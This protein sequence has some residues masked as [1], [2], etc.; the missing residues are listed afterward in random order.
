MMSG[1]DSKPEEKRLP[2]QEVIKIVKHY[3]ALTGKDKESELQT[4]WLIPMSSL[5][6][7]A[8]VPIEEFIQFLTWAVEENTHEQGSLNSVEYLAMAKDKMASLEKN[9]ES[10]FRKFKAKQKMTK[11]KAKAAQT[12]PMPPEVA[13]RLMLGYGVNMPLAGWS[14]AREKLDALKLSWYGAIASQQADPN[15]IWEELFDEAQKRKAPSDPPAKVLFIQDSTFAEE[16]KQFLSL[17]RPD[18]WP[19]E[20]AVSKWETFAMQSSAADK[21]Q[22]GWAKGER[23]A[24]TRGLIECP[25]CGVIDGNGWY[26]IYQVGY[27]DTVD[28]PQRV[29]R[30]EPVK[31]ACQG[32][33][34]IWAQVKKEI[35]AHYH[36]VNLWTLEPNAQNIL[37]LKVQ[38]EE[39][40]FVQN[41]SK[42]SFLF[43]GH[44]GTGKTTM[45]FAL[46]RQ[47][48]DRDHK[49][50]WNPEKDGIYTYETSRWIWRT[51][52]NTLLNQHNA[53]LK[54]KEAPEA[55]VTLKGIKEAGKDGKH[56]PVLV[57]EEVD[58]IALNEHRINYLLELI[59]A[60]I[61]ADGQLVLTSNLTLEDFVRTMTATDE[62]RLAGEALLRRLIENVHVRDY[63]KY[64]IA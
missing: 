7:K 47:A 49:F 6:K 4:T 34:H 52:F 60:L 38:Q 12:P 8:D 18:R 10:L 62:I 58:K 36:Y 50:F 2:K 64:K 14:S 40:T 42:E 27:C 54:D 25:I 30:K 22:S 37:P 28:G 44:P 55:D 56:K 15:I 35:P 46:F 53:T 29:F 33:K 11:H 51:N 61:E 45:A 13:Y 41:N 63:F 16:C 48:H 1:F 21:F 32:W 31:C 43:L 3:A 20:M 19:L 59:N 24:V 17:P 23:D 5:V 57:I 26:F 9:F 39:I